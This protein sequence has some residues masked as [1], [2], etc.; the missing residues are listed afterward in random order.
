[1]LKLENLNYSIEGK[2][3]LKDISLE[4]KKGKFYGILGPNGSGKSTLL[5]L[6]IGHK[7]RESGKIYLEKKEIESYSESEQGKKIS[8]LPQEFSSSF[9]YT[10]RELINMGRYPYHKLFS[11]DEKSEEVVE[12]YSSLLEI[13]HLLDKEIDSMSGG[14]RQRI[15]LGKTLVQDTDYILL[16]EA[17]SN[18][19]IFH[20]YEA[21]KIVKEEIKKTD[22]TAIAVIHDLNLALAF[23]DEIVLLKTGEVF[24][25]GDIESSLTAET[26]EE[27][28]NIQC[29]IIRVKDRKIVCVV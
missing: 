7:K 18:L 26:I 28:F 21:M 24:K 10:G 29:E 11:S 17:T 25:A 8:L 22:K 9:S 2:K 12:K 6:I 3:I 19:D 20:A 15:L 16:D 4:F 27:V 5:D 13:T 14:E 23:C 1:M